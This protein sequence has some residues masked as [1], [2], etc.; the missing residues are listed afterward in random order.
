MNGWLADVAALEVEDHRKFFIAI[1]E[2]LRRLLK[3]Q[4]L[5]PEA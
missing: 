1:V 5:L 4:D 2:Y 3:Q